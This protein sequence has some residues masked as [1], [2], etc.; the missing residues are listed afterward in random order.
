M[1]RLNVSVQVRQLSSEL[2]EKDALLATL[3]GLQQQL[4]V[5]SKQLSSQQQQQQGVAEVA[6]LQQQV[7]DLQQQL[8]AAES[9]A[10]AARAEAAAA[11]A[12]AVAA[13]GASASSSNNATLQ[14]LLSELMQLKGQLD[15][16]TARDTGAAAEGE[17]LRQ[18]V[19]ELQGQLQAA[20][21]AAETAQAAE[22]G[23][24][25]QAQA[26]VEAREQLQAELQFLQHQFEEVTAELHAVSAA[27]AEQQEQVGCR[28][29]AD[30]GCMLQLIHLIALRAA[31]CCW[32]L[33]HDAAVRCMQQASTVATSVDD[34]VCGCF[35]RCMR[36]SSSW[37]A[38]VQ[39]LVRSW[40]C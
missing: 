26:A 21:A 12:A 3:P 37:P 33:T 17:Q 40:T 20:T 9:S 32:H 30:A 18:Q 1:C 23:L 29:S 8:A 38:L 2:D 10:T 4:A 39:L 5:L 19:V 14:T 22:Q 13:A 15:A 31:A 28:H 11:V 24:Q 7:R 35:C 25:G 34:G 16:A 36:C 6:G 27:K